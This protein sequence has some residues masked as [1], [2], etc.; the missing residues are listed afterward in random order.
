MHSR[1]PIIRQVSLIVAS[2]ILVLVN[3]AAQAQETSYK[4]SFKQNKEPIAV[5]VLVG[6]SR[7]I[8]F[9]RPVGRSTVLNISRAAGFSQRTMRRSMRSMPSSAWSRKDGRS[10]ACPLSRGDGPP[11]RG[12]PP[13][14]LSRLFRH[15]RDIPARI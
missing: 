8:N 3:S 10:P 15:S 6:Q 13:P 2:L 5:N 7:V 12:S 4:A 1:F 14:A 9:D 11:G